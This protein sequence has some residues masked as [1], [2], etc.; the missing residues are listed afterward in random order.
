MKEIDG[1][2]RLFI[3]SAATRGHTGGIAKATKDF[4][5]IMVAMGKEVII[6]ETVGVG[7]NQVSV[8]QVADT[9]VLTVI[10]GMGDYLQSLK[11]GVLEIG[12]IFVVNKS[13][14]EGANRTVSDLKAFINLSCYQNE[15]KPPIMKIIATTGQGIEELMAEIYRHREYLTKNNLMISKRE[16]TMK[17]EI[18]EIIQSRILRHI[19]DRTL[20]NDRLNKY[21]Q[22]ICDGLTD[23]YQAAD[24][25]LRES[26][27]IQWMETDEP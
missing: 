12:D 23:P 15:W 1:D 19:A 13:D 26:G 9:I 11:A 7:Q 27:I 16:S 20:L 2:E 24:E 6:L 17:S 5:K 25:I 3:R 22:Q 21:V 4:I 14:R 18:L 10:P 8:I